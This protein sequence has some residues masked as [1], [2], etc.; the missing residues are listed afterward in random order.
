M[1][2]TDF[3][4]STTKRVRWPRPDGHA[5]TNAFR[6]ETAAAAAAKVLLYICFRFNNKT[7]A[8]TVHFIYLL[9]R[10]YFRYYSI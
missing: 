9:G 4:I 1:A 8:N 2:V 7:D 6:L 10:V 3:S 5:N